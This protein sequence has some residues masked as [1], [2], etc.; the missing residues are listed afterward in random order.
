MLAEGDQ[1]VKGRVLPPFRR[2][3]SNTDE[4][5]GRQWLS[6]QVIADVFGNEV[7]RALLLI[8]AYG[9]AHQDERLFSPG[10]YIKHA[11]LTPEQFQQPQHQAYLRQLESRLHAREHLDVTLDPPLLLDTG[12]IEKHR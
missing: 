11:N 5:G 2:F 3:R 12:K 1:G 9:D 8:Q 6:G 7:S 4:V 10:E